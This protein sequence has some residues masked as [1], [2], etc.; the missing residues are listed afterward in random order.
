MLCEFPRAITSSVSGLLRKDS[1]AAVDKLRRERYSIL[2]RGGCFESCRGPSIFVHPHLIA[3][4][5]PRL[6]EAHSPTAGGAAGRRDLPGHGT[7]E[8]R[9]KSPSGQAVGWRSR[10]W[11]G[12][13]G[14]LALARPIRATLRAQGSG[15]RAHGSSHHQG[16][17]SRRTAAVM[18]TGGMRPQGPCFGS[19]EATSVGAVG[20]QAK[21]P[22][23]SGKNQGRE[24]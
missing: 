20:M 6:L 9:E 18:L 8:E 2:C 17:K 19:W 11:R 16:T 21:V 3:C 1:C 15:L 24:M 10:W 23:G 22:S 12:S 13:G 4:F 5:L 14:F 7:T